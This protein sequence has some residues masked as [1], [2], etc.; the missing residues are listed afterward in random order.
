M[1][2]M[3]PAD[4]RRHDDMMIVYGE[5]RCPHFTASSNHE[6]SLMCRLEERMRRKGRR[7]VMSGAVSSPV[8]GP[9]PPLRVRHGIEVH[10]PHILP[11]HVLAVG[12]G[13]M[14]DGREVCIRTLR[15]PD[16][17]RAQGTRTRCWP[18]SNVVVAYPHLDTT[19]SQWARPRQRPIRLR[20]YPRQPANPQ[21]DTVTKLLYP[22]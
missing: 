10:S 9:S 2:L 1:T 21:P 12:E 14:I 11:Q 4:D 7:K 22:E 16:E 3:V 15:L 8:G 19:I 18:S 5:Q 17:G 13:P 6:L 20:T